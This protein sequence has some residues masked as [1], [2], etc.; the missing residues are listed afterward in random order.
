MSIER[1]RRMLGSVEPP[2]PLLPASVLVDPPPDP[3]LA[4]GV[5]ALPIAASFGSTSPRRTSGA[6]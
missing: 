4:E 3:M 1:V 2:L 6:R 5:A